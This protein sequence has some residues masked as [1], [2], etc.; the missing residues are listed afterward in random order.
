MADLSDGNGIDRR[1]SLA[2]RYATW[3]A[4]AGQVAKGFVSPPEPRFIGLVARGQQLISGSFALGGAAVEARGV[5]LWDIPSPGPQFDEA[6]QSFS[7][8]DDLAAC[9]DA[10]AR[11]LAEAWVTTWIE[12]FGRGPF[13]PVQITGQRLL[14]M[15]SHGQMLTEG[16]MSDETAPFF[17]SLSR[18]AHYLARRWKTAPPG[19]PRI[20]SLGALATAGLLLDGLGQLADPA[21][22]ALLAEAGTSIDAEGAIAS[23]NPEDLLDIFT[24]LTWLRM[25]LEDLGRSVPAELTATSGRIAPVLRALRHAD[26][27]LARF[28]GGGRGI[29]GRLDL[30]LTGSR[31]RR[32]PNMIQAMGYAR[33]SGGRTSLVVDVAS[34]PGGE[35]EATAHASTLGLELTSARRPVIVS[36]GSG[37]PFGPEWHRAGRATAS[38]ST[39]VVEGFS[40]SR[41]GK[42][43]RLSDRAAT[44]APRLF[45]SVDGQS[46]ISGHSGW[47]RSHGVQH[48]RALELSQDGRVLV[49]QD[50]LAAR[51]PEMKARLAQVLAHAGEAGIPFSLRFHLHPDVDARVDMGGAA[52]SLALR[53]G[54]IWVFRHDGTGQLSLEP[55]VYLEKGR[56]KPR[57]TLQIRLSAHLVTEQAELGWTLAKAQDTPLAIRDLDRDEPPV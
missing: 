21:I 47:A 29:E 14:R 39:L 25:T 34:P 12:R 18:Q 28:H 9:G 49:G 6:A 37:A 10:P 36:C 8:L 32:G 7:W 50:T 46:L 41:F 52:V 43:Q 17:R 35:A 51:D 31:V 1:R 23:R 16:Q 33:L 57:P 45:Q 38:H 5:N 40:S 20:E 4:G 19:L 13:W 26:G 53:S 44:L 30:A 11:A 22:S 3:R 56:L 2:D 54:E 15:I 48:L 42:G 27:N 55:S 24:L